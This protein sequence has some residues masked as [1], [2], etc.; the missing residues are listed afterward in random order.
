MV[1]EKHRPVCLIKH[2]AL[3]LDDGVA[4]EVRAFLTSA[5]Q[6]S[7]WSASRLNP[8]I[9]GVKVHGADHSD[10][11]VFARSNAGIAGSNPTHGAD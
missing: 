3:K 4:A 11:T 1:E 10:R 2:H 9:P 8:F 6:G 7:E 5:L